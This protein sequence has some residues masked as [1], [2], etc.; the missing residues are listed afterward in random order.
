MKTPVDYTGLRSEVPGSLLVGVRSAGKKLLRGWVREI[1]L[2]QCDCGGQIEDVPFYVMAGR[3]KSC[4]CLAMKTR[5]NLT[6]AKPGERRKP[7]TDITGQRFGRLVALHVLDERVNGRV[8]W[9]FQCDC[10]KQKSID[11]RY[12]RAGK[13]Q[14]CGCLTREAAVRNVAAGRIARQAKAA[15]KRSP[16]TR[17]LLPGFIPTIS[18]KNAQRVSLLGDE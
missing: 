16:L 5:V 3:R 1:W 7:V 18:H 4:G 14:S 13:S 2:W 11:G 8:H 12:V 17:C 15:A 6:P 10:G 9:M